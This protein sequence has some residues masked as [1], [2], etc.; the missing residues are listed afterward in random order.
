MTTVRVTWRVLHQ[1]CGL[2]A[3][4]VA[5]P[6]PANCPLVQPVAPAEAGS[7]GYTIDPADTQHT[8]WYNNTT[9]FNTTDSDE[10]PWSI[11]K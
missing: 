6:A 9:E 5:R 7:G 2:A 10:F 4:H 1:A 3:R 11:Y 8:W